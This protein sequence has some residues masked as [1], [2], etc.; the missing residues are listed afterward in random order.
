MEKYDITQ[1]WIHF[2]RKLGVKNQKKIFKKPSDLACI[3]I[4]PSFLIFGLAN[5][6][7]P[8]SRV[9][10]RLAGRKGGWVGWRRETNGGVGFKFQPPGKPSAIFFKAT[11]PLKPATI[12]LKINHLAFQEWL[13]VGLGPG[14]L[15]SDWI[16]LWKGLLRGIPI[17]IPNHRAPNQQL[18]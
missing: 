15:E 18:L 3:N 16:P 5:G 9:S 2:L 6:H 7:I 4:T 11:L 8:E 17:R 14:G 13:I 1:N 10:S 12:A